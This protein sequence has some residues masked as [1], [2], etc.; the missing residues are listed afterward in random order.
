MSRCKFP[1]LPIPSIP[2]L[3]LEIDFQLPVM[4]LPKLPKFG[5]PPP[6]VRLPSIS[7]PGFP[8]SIDIDLEL[9]ILKLP[10]IPKIHPDLALRI[11]LPPLS[12][13]IISFDIDLELPTFRLPTISL[14]PAC[15]LDYL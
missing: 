3:S 9:P 13:P 6:R 2:A 10:K 15:P 12:I 5:V 7:I 1:I 14:L 4:K 11:S 8:I